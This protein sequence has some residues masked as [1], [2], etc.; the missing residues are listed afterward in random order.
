MLIESKDTRFN[1]R[2]QRWGQASE[3]VMWHSEVDHQT[4]K[5]QQTARS[6]PAPDKRNAA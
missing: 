3:S 6:L 4:A 1:H 5:A 2:K